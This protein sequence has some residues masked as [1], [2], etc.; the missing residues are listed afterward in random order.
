MKLEVQIQNGSKGLNPVVLNDVTLE[1]ERK[2]S[3][4]KLTLHIL[5]DGVEIE[6]GN[7]IKLIVD[8]V[9]MFYGYIFKISRNSTT[10]ITLMAYDQMRYLKN[11]DTYVFSNTTANRIAA[12]IAKDYGINVGEL[13]ETAYLIQSVVYDNKTLM[14]MIQ[15]ALEMTLTNNKTLYVLYDDCG[16]LTIRQAA[17]MKVGLLID[18]ETAESFD[19][20]ST[21]DEETYNR[22]ILEHEDSESK[23]RSYW[24]A[25]DPETQKKWGTLQYFESIDKKTNA[26]QKADTLLKLYN[27]KTKHLTIKNAIG[28]KRVR[29]GSMI[30]VQ[31]KIGDTRLNNFMV[32]NS[33]KHTFTENQHLMTLKLQGGEFVA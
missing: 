5:D 9:A 3:P 17:R 20:D 6:E 16:K 14:D 26:Q 27:T 21:I 29:G 13:E 15:D 24:T 8:G 2:G 32:V 31:L 22:I 1:T 18:A 7:P 4:G 23:Q 10:E 19:Y 12:S 25:E 11:K 28:D 30:M 33:C